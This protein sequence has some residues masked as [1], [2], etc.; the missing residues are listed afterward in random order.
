MTKDLEHLQHLR[1]KFGCKN[2]QQDMARSVAHKAGVVVRLQVCGKNK[3]RLD[4][5]R[6][7]GQAKSQ[8]DFQNDG[9]EHRLTEGI[10]KGRA[11]VEAPVVTVSEA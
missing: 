11:R 3:L 9:Q 1:N 2:S 6:I 10:C 7:A 4:R 8:I 5:S